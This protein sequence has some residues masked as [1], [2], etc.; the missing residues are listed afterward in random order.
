MENVLVVVHIAI[1][2]NGITV[3]H[4]VVGLHV[5]YYHL[6]FSLEFLFSSDFYQVKINFSIQFIPFLFLFFVYI[7]TNPSRRPVITEQ[8]NTTINAIQQNLP[9]DPNPT[10]NASSTLIRCIDTTPV[11]VY[12]V[13]AQSYSRAPRL[14]AFN[15]YLLCFLLFILK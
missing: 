8:V 3:V 2:V 1:F 12:T 9:C 5:Y 11:Y 15:S 10:F 4:F 6:D 13:V 7:E 14:S